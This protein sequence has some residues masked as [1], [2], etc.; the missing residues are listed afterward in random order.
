MEPQEQLLEASFERIDTRD[1]FRRP[2]NAKQRRSSAKEIAKIAQD[3]IS[4]FDGYGS[5]ASAT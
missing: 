4:G 5:P 3:R 1:G 2:D